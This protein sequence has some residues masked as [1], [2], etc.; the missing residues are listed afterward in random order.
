MIGDDEPGVFVSASVAEAIAERLAP[1]A[2]VIVPNRFELRTSRDC[3]SSRW[4][5]RWPPRQS[6]APT[7]PRW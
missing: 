1:L 3:G 7:A 5:M 2:D 4:R 6:C